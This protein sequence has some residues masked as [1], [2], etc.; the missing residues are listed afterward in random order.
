MPDSNIIIACSI[1]KYYLE[2]LIKKDSIN[3][4]IVYVDSMLHM[5]PD[6][7]EAELDKELE[8][9]K[10]RNIMLVFGDCHSRMIDY[11]ER[12]NVFRTQGVNCCEICLG[13][14][15]YNK[16]RREKAFI[17]FPE[18]LV[19][20]KEIFNTYFQFKDSKSASQFMNEMHEKIVFINNGLQNV[21][22][23]L[24]TDISNYLG[25]PLEIIDCSCKEFETVLNSLIKKFS[26][27][28]IK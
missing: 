12:N 27:N 9:Y 4:P 13:H 7:L 15:H 19:R 17:L 18:W 26:K 16:L 1:F 8:K 25:L 20:W 11:E 24:L 10:D 2:H 28:D 14:K 22:S 21:N 5:H 6:K 3:I 23:D